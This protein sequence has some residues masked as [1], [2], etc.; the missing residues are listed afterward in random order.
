MNRDDHDLINWVLIYIMSS[1]PGFW[2][3]LLFP[4][5]LPGP[6]ASLPGH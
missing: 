6:V 2:L 3:Y 5:P 1:L 4:L